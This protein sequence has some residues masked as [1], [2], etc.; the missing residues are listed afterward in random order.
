MAAKKLSKCLNRLVEPVMRHKKYTM[1]AIAGGIYKCWKI[2]YCC[3]LPAI[4]RGLLLPYGGNRFFDLD[5]ST[6]NLKLVNFF[7]LFADLMV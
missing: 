6:S 4:A 3:H 5:N 1:G 7:D 2:Y